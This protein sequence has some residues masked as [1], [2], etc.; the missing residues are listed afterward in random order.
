MNKS[1]T[2]ETVNDATAEVVAKPKR[3]TKAQIEADA[4]SLPTSGAAE[5]APAA[6]A[7]RK[8]KADAAVEAAAPVAAA[9]VAAPAAADAPVPVKKPRAKPVAKAAVEAV[10]AVEPAP[11]AAPAPAGTMS[12]LGLAP[13]E[14]FGPLGGLPDGVPPPAG[15]SLLDAAANPPGE[16]LP[17]TSPKPGA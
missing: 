9:P 1:N 2:P 15:F 16:G 14:P 6:K 13:T 7:K 11:Q 4:A 5:A 12:L 3:R 10:Q 8:P 17:I